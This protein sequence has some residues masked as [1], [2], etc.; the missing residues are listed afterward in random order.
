MA[1]TIVTMV[2]LQARKETMRKATM[3]EKGNHKFRRRSE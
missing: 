3:M 2:C 1:I